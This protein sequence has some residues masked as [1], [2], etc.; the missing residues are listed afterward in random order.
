MNAYS[1]VPGGRISFGVNF[2]DFTELNSDL[3]AQGLAEFQDKQSSEDIGLN[4]GTILKRFYVGGK[5]NIQKI[6]LEF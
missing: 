3:K 6:I 2:I 1:E 5:A 4:G